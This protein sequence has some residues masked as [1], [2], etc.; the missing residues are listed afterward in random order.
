MSSS[1][2]PTLATGIF[3]PTGGKP[4]LPQISLR[5]SAKSGTSASILASSTTTSRAPSPK[6]ASVALPWPRTRMSWPRRW[7]WRAE[8]INGP[9]RS[10]PPTAQQPFLHPRPRA[11][12]STRSTSP[13]S[14]R[15]TAAWTPPRLAFRRLPSGSPLRRGRRRSSRHSTWRS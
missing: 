5:S 14:W 8:C 15:T 6:L 11:L 7:Q 12:P 3:S 2:T 4:C 9:P 10:G 13:T 1:S